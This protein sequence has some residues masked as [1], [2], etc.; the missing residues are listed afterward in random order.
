MKR[1]DFFNKI[2][3]FFFSVLFFSF[4]F[5]S[6]KSFAMKERKI[7]TLKEKSKVVSVFHSG[8]TD[9]T[10]KLDN[11]NLDAN[12]VKRMVDEG[13]KR[14]TGV[15][16]LR[17]AWEKIIPDPSRKVAIKINCQITG[18]YTKSKVVNPIIDG[19][20]LRGVKPDN[21]IIY[22]LTDNAFE[23]AGFKKNRGSGVKVGKTSD[24][25]GYSR[26]F[27]NRM[28]NL[29]TGGH[30]YSPF[31]LMDDYVRENEGAFMSTPAKY[32][33]SKVE[34]NYD[35]HYLINVPVLKAL[36]GYSG[37]TLSMKNHYGSIGNPHNHH[38][39]IMDFIPF[40]N[41]QP[42]I[43]DKTRLIVMDAI[44]IEYKWQNKE[45]RDYI[46][47]LNQIL[48]SDDTVAIDYRGW[49][50]IEERRKAHQMEPLSPQP[51]FIRTAALMG[52]GYDDPERIEQEFVDLS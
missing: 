44:F 23:V 29:L 39:D 25:G 31:N 22:D 47:I 35:C 5:K 30:N 48:V 9:G 24:F 45:K 3:S 37:V 28:A 13:I 20:V 14:F 34:R 15:D 19:L 41:N 4:F 36:D 51:V 7:R 42:Q 21:I 10:G 1:R 50:M 2:L 46:D 43:R 12:V 26:F 16:N 17:G 38:D 11:A 18:I 27:Y 52:L 40:L 32:I 6:R 33:I 8:A 49:K